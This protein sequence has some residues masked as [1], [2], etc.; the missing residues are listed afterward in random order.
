MAKRFFYVCAG[1]LCLAFAYHLGARNAT[2][3]S[4]GTGSIKLVEAWGGYIAV[5]DASDNI[6]VVDPQKLRDVAKGNG[7]WKFNLSAV[8]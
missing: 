6:Y 1:I 2:A 8:K 5:V 4:Q 7:W 3:Q